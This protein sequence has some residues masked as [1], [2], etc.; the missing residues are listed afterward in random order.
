MQKAA[1]IDAL[2]NVADDKHC[3]HHS[4]N[5]SLGAKRSSRRT[6]GGRFVVLL[7]ASKTESIKTS[8]GPRAASLRA[9]RLATLCLFGASLPAIDAAGI[10]AVSLPGRDENDIRHGRMT[11][12]DSRMRTRR[13]TGLRTVPPR[14]NSYSGA[15]GLV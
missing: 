2:C 6:N 9:V 4:Y 3:H 1:P 8:Y 5:F 13:S 10:A 15:I 7:T 12:M 11:P 14:N